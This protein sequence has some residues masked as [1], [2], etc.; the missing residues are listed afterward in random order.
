MSSP[1]G[2]ESDNGGCLKEKVLNTVHLSS[3]RDS[4]RANIEQL[5]SKFAAIPQKP[6]FMNDLIK[7]GTGHIPEAVLLQNAKEVI[8]ELTVR[9]AH[10]LQ[11]LRNLP[12]LIVLN[13]SISQIYSLYF[14]SFFYMLSTPPPQTLAENDEFTCKLKQLVD[15]HTDTIPTLAKGF[16][17]CRR[18]LST[19]ISAQILDTHL[20]DRIGTRV[21]AEHHIFLT[22]PIAPNFI[23]T[24]QMNFKPAV[25]L[26]ECSEFVGD[27]CEIKFGIKPHLE[28]DQAG[29]DVELP[30][31]PVH[32]EYMFTELLKNS[33]RASV[34]RAIGAS[35][36]LENGDKKLSETPVIATIVKTAQGV[37]VRIRDCGG[38]IPP[39][40]EDRIFGFAFSTFEDNEGDGYSTLNNPP[41]NGGA[42]IAGMGYGLP[43]TRA[44]AEFFGGNLRLQSYYGLGTDVY[45][46]LHGPIST[47]ESG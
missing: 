32:A 29:M 31:V 40:V 8:E 5:I 35:E 4:I 11:A 2:L 14:D 45:V 17:E 19:D 30:Y 44:Y 43:L 9:L 22:N 16:S 38:G 12:Y 15:N 25:M 36:I 42:S 26:R 3:N 39:A 23:G 1:T 10:R 46:T 13:P 18:Y 47:V 37:M 6:I 34:E 28:I 27:I 21:L 24:V 20:R 7:F 41:G 33:F